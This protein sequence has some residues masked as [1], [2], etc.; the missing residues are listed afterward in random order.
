MSALEAVIEA[1]EGGTTSPLYLIAGDRVVSEPAGLQL[2]EKLAEPTGTEVEVRRR[3]EDMTSLLADLQT[4]ALF[5]PGKVVVAVDTALLADR[6]AA[7]SLIDDAAEVLP[8]AE[9]S[10]LGGRSRQ[11]AIRLFQALRLFQVDPYKGPANE[12]LEEL[13]AWAFA[14]GAGFKRKRRRGRAKKEAE[15]LRASLAPLLEAG[16]TA[17]I[18][19]AAE[20]AVEALGDILQRG[21][22][23]GHFLILVEAA[24]AGD[25]PLVK[26]LAERGAL[27]QLSQVTS[28][29]QGW[30]GLQPLV[31][32]LERETG[33][34]IESQAIQALAGRTLRHKGAFAR[35]GDAADG[36]SSARFAA[37]YR[38]LATLAVG[39]KIRLE[40][41]KNTIAD[42]G[43]QDVW[44]ILDAIGSGAAGDAAG[45][46]ERFL[47]GAQD[48]TAA[49]L[50]F[51]SL[52][53]GF[54][55]QLSVISGAFLAQQV[56]PGERN[57]RNFKSRIA[58]RLQA[59]L[60]SGGTNPIAS[61]HPYRLHR[62][63]LAASRLPGVRLRTLSARVVETEALL[64]GGSSSPDTALLAFVSDLACAIK[65]GRPHADG[66]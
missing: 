7:A 10:E 61:L 42:R 27:V 59:P 35:S 21:L 13:P 12:V 14:G 66:C 34:G 43:E 64:K 46:L 47:G 9:E 26:A 18:Q 41:V 15:R 60:P 50:S 36:E 63:Y 62:A 4:F 31:R 24:V 28:R 44:S 33:V 1:L 5:S 37:E 39:K 16:R 55:R 30:E 40:L 57:Y 3:P 53:A 8:L 49:R 17:E 54:C 45:R 58:P 38:K 29:R 25:H 52:L 51:W 6:E 19:G 56:A 2:G 22:P 11:A 48:P 65:A 23:E 32:E 20:S